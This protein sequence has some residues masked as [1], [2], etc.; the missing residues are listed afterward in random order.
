LRVTAPRD[1]GRYRALYDM[2]RLA[3]AGRTGFA[4]GFGHILQLVGDNPDATFAAAFGISYVAAHYCGL[5]GGETSYRRGLLGGGRLGL[6][7]RRL[8]RYGGGFNGSFACRCALSIAR[9][10]ANISSR[11]KTSWYSGWLHSRSVLCAHRSSFTGSSG[12]GTRSV[13]G[14]TYNR[15]RRTRWLDNGPRRTCLCF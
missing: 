4:P 15:F 14:F 6:P 3:L 10:L 8:G 11:P 1:L 5:L 12:G 9:A 7:G 2:S 13:N